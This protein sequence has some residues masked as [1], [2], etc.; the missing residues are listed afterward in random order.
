MFMDSSDQILLLLFIS[1]DDVVILRHEANT[2]LS[3]IIYYFQIP[4]HRQSR[5]VG[6]IFW[7]FCWMNAEEARILTNDSKKIYGSFGDEID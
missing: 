5:L 3:C 1:G 7:P 2:S 4:Y 6:L